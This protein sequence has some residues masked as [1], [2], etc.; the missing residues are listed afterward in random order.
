VS[1]RVPNADIEIDGK[2]EG[3]PNSLGGTTYIIAFQPGAGANVPMIEQIVKSYGT[4][5]KIT[6][7]TWALVSMSEKAPAV[8]NRLLPHIGTGGRLFVIKSG[9]ESA[10]SNV[11][12]T[13]EWLQRYLQN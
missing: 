5:A 10:W 3:M 9:Y 6:D 2:L 8:R 11:V 13:T 7:Q 4:W 1:I 12:S